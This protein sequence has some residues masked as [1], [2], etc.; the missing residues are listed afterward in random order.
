MLIFFGKINSLGF[1]DFVVERTKT[2]AKCL[3]HAERVRHIHVKCLFA[4]PPKLKINF[5]FIKIVS[6]LEILLAGLC[7]A[8]VIVLLF[9]V[10]V[11]EEV[12]DLW[13]L[14]IATGPL[15][16]RYTLLFRHS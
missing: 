4:I 1:L 16:T 9:I 5:T 6:Q 3:E 7:H 2:N 13:F 8:P 12:H 10:A 15:Q 11:R 14:H